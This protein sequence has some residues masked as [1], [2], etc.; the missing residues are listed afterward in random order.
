MSER[1][2]PYIH[3]HIFLT[4][5]LYFSDPVV[6]AEVNKWAIPL[7]NYTKTKLGETYVD[8]DSSKATCRLA[9]CSMG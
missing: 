8:L 5:E 9:E 3:R 1:R 4:V 6:L 2:I 7:Q